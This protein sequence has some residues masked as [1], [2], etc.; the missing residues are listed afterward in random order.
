MDKPT[1]PLERSLTNYHL[2]LL[3]ALLMTI[4]HIGAVLLPEVESLRVIGRLSFPL[5]VW[6]LVQGEAHTRNFSRYAWRLF[7]WGCISQYFYWLAFRS[8]QLNILFTLLLGLLCLRGARVAPEWQ[9]AIWVAGAGLATIA[10]MD[11]AGYG[12]LIIALLSHFQ[13]HLLWWLGWLVLHIAFAIALPPFG[14]SQF[15]AVF[16]P[17][18][19]ISASGQQGARARWF[20]LFYPVHLLVLVLVRAYLS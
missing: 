3:A 14:F 13:R 20:Y 10:R 1:A 17:L 7:L 4:D 12:I 5:F 16:A 6:L 18:I 9:L 15:P 2:K 8:D 11:Y 19:L